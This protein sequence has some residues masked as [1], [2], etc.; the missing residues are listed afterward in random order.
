MPAICAPMFLVSGPELVLAAC[1]A[2]VLGVLPRQNARSL[3]Q[4]DTWLGS[5][6]AALAAA[7]AARPEEKIAPVA[8]NLPAK[9]PPEEI[10]AALEVAEAYAVELVISVA[11]NPREVVAQAHGKGM[12]VYHD[13]IDLYFAEKAIAAGVDGLIAIGSGGGGHSG[14]TSHLALLPKLRQ[15]FSGPLVLAGGI[16]DGAGI[17]AGQALGADLVYLGTRFIATEEARA[18]EAYKRMLVD[19]S[20][21]DLIYSDRITGVAAN[22]LRPSLEAAG[23]DCDALPAPQGKLRHDHL[24]DGVRPWRDL[25]SA[26]QGIDL[27]ADIPSAGEL[28]RRL[29]AEYEAA[30]S[31]LQ[32]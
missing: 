1:K 10:A 22:W 20:S 26:G 16:S 13:V 15:S 25:W 17:C 7:R 27:I 12:E 29:V 28:V 4:F 11:G 30:R 5:I 19:C 3:E 21:T 14:T 24:P 2:G 8:I 6:S 9:L 31:R 23:L 18:P 32:S